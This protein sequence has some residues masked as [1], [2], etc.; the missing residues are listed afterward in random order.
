M[1]SLMAWGITF[2]IIGGLSLFLYKR[3]TKE[4]NIKMDIINRRH[5]LEEIKRE[6]KKEEKENEQT[7]IKNP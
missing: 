4:Q 1:S 5:T 2:I 7:N 6:L 3:T